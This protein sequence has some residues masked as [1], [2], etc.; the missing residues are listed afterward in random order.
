MQPVESHCSVAQA[1]SR[2]TVRDGVSRRV[3]PEVLTPTAHLC[4]CNDT[5]HGRGQKSEKNISYPTISQ[6]S[7]PG[8]PAGLNTGARRSRTPV[9]RPAGAPGTYFVASFLANLFDFPIPGPIRKSIFTTLQLGCCRSPNPPLTP[10]GL[11]PSKA[12]IGL[13]SASAQTS[14]G[15]LQNDHNANNKLKKCIPHMQIND[16]RGRS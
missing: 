8:S 2:E 1:G 6:K 5:S 13:V 16:R 12:S 9:L 11:P 10:E 14:R 3:G 7:N 15:R 4:S